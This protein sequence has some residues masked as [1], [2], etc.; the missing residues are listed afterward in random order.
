MKKHFVSLASVVVVITLCIIA[1]YS[2]D[3]SVKTFADE[4]QR[5]HTLHILSTNRAKLEAALYSRLFLIKGLVVYVATHPDITQKEF[6]LYSR[7][8]L[9]RDK[10]IIAVQL[11]RNS[12]ISHIYPMQGNEKVLGLNLL[13]TDLPPEQREALRRA[14][15]TRKTVVAGPVK[16]IQGGTAFI[17]RTPVYVADADDDNSRKYWGLATV[18]ISADALFEEAGLL[19]IH[20]KLT[21]A[22]RGKDGLGSG[23]ALFFG[24]GDVFRH[25]PVK[26]EVT[27]PNGQWVLAAIPRNGWQSNKYSPVLWSLGLLFTFMASVLI[28][29]LVDTPQRLRTKVTQATEHLKTSQSQQKALLNG[30]PDAAWL[31]DRDGRFLAVNATFARQVGLPAEDIIGKTDFDIIA[32]EQA[33]RFHRADSQVISSRKPLHTENEEVDAHGNPR[34]VE[35]VKIPIENAD[36]DIIGTTGVAH[37]VT[38]RHKAETLIRSSHAEAENLVQRRTA[39]LQDANQQLRNEIQERRKTE[40]ELRQ[41]RNQFQSLA[42]NLPDSIFRINKDNRIVFVNSAAQRNWFSSSAVTAGIRLHETELPADVIGLW[43]LVCSSVFT[44][45]QPRTIEFAVPA[46]D[47][48]RYYEGRYLAERNE[49]GAVETILALNRDITATRQ[50]RQEL[51]ESEERYRTLV[52]HA[53]DG[54]FLTDET[55]RYLE[56]N[57]AGLK[58]LG[59]SLDELRTLSIQD[60]I[61]S[62]NAGTLQMA[63][64]AL[65]NG[66]I[67]LE[68][69]EM[70]CRDG[71]LVPVE[72]SAVMLKDGTVQGIARDISQRRKAEQQRLAVEE[73]MRQQQ[74]LEAIGTLASGV[75]HEINNPL[76]II[77]NYAQLI[78]DVAT[79]ESTIAQNAGEILFEGERIATIV[80]NLLDF[81]RKEREETIETTVVSIVEATESLMHKFLSKDQITVTIDIPDNLPVLTCNRQQIMQV[82]INLI[83]NSRDA[84]NERYPGYDDDKLLNIGATLITRDDRQFIRIIVEDHGAGIP[85]ETAPR[86]FDPFF[87]SK[88]RNQGTG[89]GLSIS[90]D[91]A[92]K[93]DGSLTMESDEDGGTRFYLDL[94]VSP[95]SPE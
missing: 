8:L 24:P 22:I 53:S 83:T 48:L 14:I 4:Q 52:N 17:S 15:T 50:A 81:S 13:S 61:V 26:L 7:E 92:Q 82:L 76:N 84:L 91:I 29:I 2:V 30:L 56:S 33:T 12:V 39:E 78:Q 59:Y 40:E 9:V 74:K 60:L 35:T 89:L 64:E 88:G 16:L 95:V 69:H 49:Q 42:N 93:H 19:D 6:A 34:W 62:G 23:G 28:F 41:Q 70:Q 10:S 1:M 27:I 25:D 73:H 63:F 37:D 47:G 36:G 43:E 31:K 46:A 68:E 85:P 77:M 32:Q 90:Y 5:S 71:S 51:E 67:L 55:G 80:R 44:T 21:Y 18:L 94:P 38:N 54:I 75:A 11:A 86:I 58:M 87:T 72:I 45:G 65:S 66:K 57:R 20:N 3:Q 79:G